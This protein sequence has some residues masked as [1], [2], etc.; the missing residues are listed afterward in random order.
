MFVTR[1]SD[2]TFGGFHVDRRSRLVG[3][4]CS[5]HSLRALVH[6]PHVFCEESRS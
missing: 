5:I 4:R 6:L 2:K 1:G 3:R